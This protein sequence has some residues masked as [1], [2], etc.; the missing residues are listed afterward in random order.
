ME[1]EEIEGAVK[2]VGSIRAAAKVLGVSARLIYARRKE[3]GELRKLGR[4]AGESPTD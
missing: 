2:S 4:P 1:I 3:A